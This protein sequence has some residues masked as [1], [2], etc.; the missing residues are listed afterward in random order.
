M[1]GEAGY[2]TAIVPDP[3]L[4]KFTLAIDDF[5]LSL[6]PPEAQQRGTPAFRDAVRAYLSAEFSRF[7]GW[8]SIDVD[9]H[10][11]EVSWTPDRQPADPL[12]QIVEKLKHGEYPGAITLLRLFLSDKPNDLP[13]LY[14]LGMALSDTGQLD[15]AANHLRRAVALADDFTNARIA[16]AVA[17]Q[18]QGKNT[19]AIATLMEAVNRA[20][21]NP[22]AHRNLGACLLKAG[23]TAEA[24]EY[25]RQ[26]TLLD[27]KDQQAMF[28]LA[29]VLVALG[30]SKEAHD[31]Y[32]KVID[33]DEYSK[34]AKA[35]Q[36]AL[37]KIAEQS[38][39]TLTP[40]TPRPDAVMYCLGALETFAKMSRADVQ[41]IAFE[42]AAKGQSG[43]DTNDP[44]PKYQLKS[45]AGNFSGLH[46]V[47][48]LYVAFKSIA[49][50]ADVG[51]DLSKEYAAAQALHG[52]DKAH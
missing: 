28:G 31:A 50:E 11:I 6:L 32:K 40:G 34:I 35:A 22:T 44:T 21:E 8:S 13:L 48:L 14:N 26:A 9:N 49:Q 42:I 12:A 23:R 45:L 51:F 41:T 25:L 16:L 17:L 46:L 30:R 38:F 19:E 15:D 29:E 18:R 39:K 33:L 24:E 10:I 2:K 3:S 20:P 5:D 43:L 1:V 7:G 37:R 47:C 36:D 27:P 52:G 4:L